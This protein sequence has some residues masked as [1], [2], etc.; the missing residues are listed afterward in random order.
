V[1]EL[2]VTGPGVP[3]LVSLE[4]VGGRV[5]H[6]RLHSDHHA[7]LTRLN[8]QL[9]KINRSPATVVTEAATTDED[10]LAQVNG[11][12]A[13]ATI[14]D[15]YIYDRWSAGYPKTAANRDVAVSQDG[16]LAWVVRKDSPKLLEVVNE[17]FAGHRLAF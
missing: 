3:P 10:L 11:G 12:Q 1:R 17:F 14:V 5:I 7:S 13:P 6:V 16:E 15:D 9:K 2:V 4:D 8:D